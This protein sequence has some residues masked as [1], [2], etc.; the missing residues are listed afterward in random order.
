M[1]TITLTSEAGKKYKAN[2]TADSTHA[3]FD[4][5]EANDSGYAL[6]IDNSNPRNLTVNVV[7][8]RSN[9]QS[10]VRLL[11]QAGGVIYAYLAGKL[12]KNQFTASI[13]KDNFPDGIVQFTL[14]SVSGEPM[15]ERLVFIRNNRSA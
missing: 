6:S 15:N 7:A 12:V 14:F 5:P 2:L 10:E 1:G 11:A 9:H 3:V 13:P 8:G 4:L